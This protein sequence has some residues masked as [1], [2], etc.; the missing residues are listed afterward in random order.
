MTSSNPALC[1]AD[2][3]AVLATLAAEHDR[4][5]H[6]VNAEGRGPNVE[7]LPTLLD[8]VDDEREGE[9]E[10]RVRRG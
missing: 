6:A 4:R 9:E 2:E 1:L 3:A 7:D 8:E 5:R 10:A